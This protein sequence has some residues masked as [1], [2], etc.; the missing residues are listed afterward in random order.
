M[1]DEAKINRILAELDAIRLEVKSLLPA[2]RTETKSVAV[3]MPRLAIMPTPNPL[4]KPQ[5]SESTAVE[6]FWEKV[7]DWL[8]VR[9]DFAPSGMTREFGV[10]TRWLTRIGSVLI[11]GAIA[12]FLMLAIDKGWIGPT[13]RVYGMMTWGVIGTAY[14]TWLKLKSEKYAILGEVCAA[15]GLVAVYLS[16]GLGHRFFSPPVIASGYVAFA[17][18][19]AATIAAG[20]LSV[21]LR[22]L[23]I[24]CLALAGGFLVPTICSFANHDV[25]LH[26]YLIVLSLGACAVAYFRNWPLFGFAAIALSAVLSTTQAECRVLAYL[27]YAFE[28]VL[29]VVT[30]AWTSLRHVE[31]VRRL[32][33]GAVAFAGICSFGCASQLVSHGGVSC[34]SGAMMLHRLVWGC[35]FA[36]LAVLSKRFAWG[37][38]PG[39]F[40]SSAL[41]F[42]VITVASYHFGDEF[43]PSLRGGF[44][45]IVWAV[46]ASA[47]LAAGIVRRS[48]AVR[49][50][51]LGILAASV[52]KLLLLDTS[53]LATPGRVGVFAAVGILLIA[54]AFLYLRFESRFEEV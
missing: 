24:A 42:L 4:L 15:V 20:V 25:Q 29:V 5:A 1:Q 52:V 27:F 40:A 48:K 49:L 16:F 53:S 41:T 46:V 7:E 26:I 51:G 39:V 12:Y 35:A 44:V 8:Y 30:A 31:T 43:L 36:A 37:G 19:F 10:A 54:G 22:S 28:F 17:G 34:C 9:G 23:M 47:L 18:L 38:M 33:W 21:R 3:P 50:S 45:T 2:H 14:G 11:I 6:R 13:Q 32:C